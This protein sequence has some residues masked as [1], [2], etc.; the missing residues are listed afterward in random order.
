MAT[1]WFFTAYVFKL[2]IFKSLY[3]ISVQWQYNDTAVKSYRVGVLAH[4]RFARW[5]TIERR[6][7]MVYG[8]GGFCKRAKTY[9]K[10][11][12]QY[13]RL[14]DFDSAQ[15]IFNDNKLDLFSFF[16]H[17]AKLHAIASS[18][19]LERELHIYTLTKTKQGKRKGEKEREERIMHII[20]KSSYLCY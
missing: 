4:V 2:L 6:G 15:L 18:G 13:Q 1:C 10:D 20:K 12:L 19:Q 16:I 14:K 3:L 8:K 7:Y 17:L 11:T 5:K 9:I